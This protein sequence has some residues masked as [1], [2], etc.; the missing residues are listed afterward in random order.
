[1]CLLRGGGSNI[2]EEGEGLRADD[3]ATLDV[4]RDDRGARLRF[5]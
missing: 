2:R 3:L 4:G 1:M 5:A